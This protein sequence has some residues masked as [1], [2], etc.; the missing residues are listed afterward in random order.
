M[1]R[2]CTFRQRT[3]SC[4]LQRLLPTTSP[5]CCALHRPIIFPPLFFFP[6]VS[7]SYTPN[8]LG[9]ELADASF[10]PHCFSCCCYLSSSFLASLSKGHMMWRSG[11][12]FR[13]RQPP[14]RPIDSYQIGRRLHVPAPPLSL[15]IGGPPVSVLFN[16]IRFPSRSRSI[17]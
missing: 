3:P 1:Y 4:L 5:C 8:M 2:D 12:W 11:R 9:I 10:S 13:F 6:N 17:R 7:T 14:N 16:S 15:S